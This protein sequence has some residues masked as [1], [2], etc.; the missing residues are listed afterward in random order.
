MPR[1]KGQRLENKVERRYRSI[2][3]SLE[4]DEIIG[5][6]AERHNISRNKVMREFINHSL[7]QYNRREYTEG[8]TLEHT[9]QG[10]NNG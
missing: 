8:S 1:L 9:L 2:Y 4:V 6:V 10:S 3:I 7:K 5:E